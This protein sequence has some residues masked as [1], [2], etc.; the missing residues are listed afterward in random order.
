MECARKDCDK[1]GK[2]WPILRIW[3]LGC[4][5][6]DHE[7]LETYPG[8]IH[9]DE[10][11]EKTTVED[12]V[13]EKGWNAICGA[14]AKMGAAPPDRSTVELRWTESPPFFVKMDA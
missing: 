8:L 10:C 14:L 2:H 11:K 13:G 7:P 12:L 1:E 6:G 4:A 9:C 3:A 5:P